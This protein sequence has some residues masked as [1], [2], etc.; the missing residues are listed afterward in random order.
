VFVVEQ[1]VDEGGVI[2]LLSA[3]GEIRLLRRT[4]D[5]L[6]GRKRPTKVWAKEGV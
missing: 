3:I 5:F 6:V 2:G 1:V 4:H